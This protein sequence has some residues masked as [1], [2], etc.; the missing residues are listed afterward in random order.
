MI[1]VN[2]DESTRKAMQLQ[3]N[4]ERERRA[5]VTLAEGEKRAAELRADAE[6]YTA[7][8]QADARRVAAEAEAFATATLAK[9]INAN[10]LDAVKFELT[11]RQI[12]AL[13]TISASDNAKF[14]LLPS[15]ISQ[16][17]SGFAGFAS[18]LTP[19][20]SRTD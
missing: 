16:A 18:M 6:F 9:A 20:D 5:A 7:Q 11:K 15:E 1:D 17:F 13:G 12:E 14:I 4:A 3:I 8:K 19:S 10:G 2:V